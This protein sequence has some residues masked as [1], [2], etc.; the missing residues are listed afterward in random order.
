LLDATSLAAGEVKRTRFAFSLRPALGF[1]SLLTFSFVLALTVLPGQAAA[2]Y[3]SIVVEADSGRV[4]HSKNADTR[5]YPASLTKIMT[6]YMV[7]EALDRGRLTLDTRMKTSRRATGMSPSKL[8]LKRGETITVRDAIMA[9]IT[10]SANDAA[11]V[12][13]EHLGGTEQKFARMMTKRARALGMKRTSFRNA[14]GLPNRRQ[15]STARD[16]STLARRIYKDFPHY[17]G[18]FA[19]KSFKFRGRSY[20]N[21]N[22]LL[23]NYSGTDGIK[24][25]YIRASG[26]N[27]VASVERDGRRLIGVVFGGRTARSRDRHMAKLLDKG[28]RKGGPAIAQAKPAKRKTAAKPPKRKPVKV[29]RKAPHPLPKPARFAAPRTTSRTLVVEA[30]PAAK[31]AG[32]WSAQVGAFRQADNARKAARKASQKLD[33]IGRTARLVIAPFK[34]ESGQLYRAR[35]TGLT[36]A[37]ARQACRHLSAQRI[38][39]VPVAPKVAGANLALNRN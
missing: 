39:C 5:N 15:L 19:S 20:R 17:Y 23:S 25:G 28:F 21:H 8:G 31:P 32:S 4:L 7:F 1:I 3:A 12:V 2:R 13:A 35:L 33:M 29:A 22:R 24:T 18:Y 6:L 37:K 26:F 36:E 14:S 30:A 10:K 34:T 11:V 9:L 27:L 16:M 38:S